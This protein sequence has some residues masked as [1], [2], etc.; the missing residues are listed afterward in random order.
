MKKTGDAEKIQEVYPGKAAEV[1]RDHL[2]R[3]GKAISDF[4]KE[5]K[6]AF[7]LEMQPIIFVA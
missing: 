6:E 3:T 5:E 2:L 7:I 1:V 4:D